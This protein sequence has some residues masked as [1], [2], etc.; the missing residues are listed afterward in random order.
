MIE[1]AT[2]SLEEPRKVEAVVKRVRVKN[3]SYVSL[4]FPSDRTEGTLFQNLVPMVVARGI[5]VAFQKTAFDKGG[6]MNFVRGVPK[7][8]VRPCSQMYEFYESVYKSLLTSHYMCTLP[9][10]FVKM[11]NQLIR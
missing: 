2:K 9:L 3:M 10:L 5:N 1:S 4:L 6:E 8:P 7:T 11:Y